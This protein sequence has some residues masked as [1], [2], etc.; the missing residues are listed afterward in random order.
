[1]YIRLERP[2][3]G[4]DPWDDLNILV[5]IK[6]NQLYEIAVTLHHEQKFSA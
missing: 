3:G 4:C 6:H 1:M 2:V 5:K